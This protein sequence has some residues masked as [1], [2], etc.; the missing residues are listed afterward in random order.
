MT[1]MKDYGD[2][3]VVRREADFAMV[4]RKP[5]SGKA[6]LSTYA[7]GYDLLVAIEAW[8]KEVLAK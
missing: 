8:A 1:A 2:L 7:N 4:I 5:G 3:R 6:T